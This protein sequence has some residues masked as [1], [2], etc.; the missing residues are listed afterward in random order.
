MYIKIKK[1]VN[2]GRKTANPFFH[3]KRVGNCYPIVRQLRMI[4]PLVKYIRVHVHEPILDSQSQYPR[5]SARNLCKLTVERSD[6]AWESWEIEAKNGAWSVKTKE[7]DRPTE[8]SSYIIGINSIEP[9]NNQQHLQDNAIELRSDAYHKLKEVYEQRV[10]EYGD[11]RER[12]QIGFTSDGYAPA[13]CHCNDKLLEFI[14]ESKEFEVT[15][16]TSS[17]RSKT[18]KDYIKGKI[19]F[20]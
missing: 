13:S 15:I 5:G 20:L 17:S 3:D 11:L 6:N 16:K 10:A 1:D 2:E 8:K 9:Y 4:Y 14:K 18:V 7:V 12:R 19:P